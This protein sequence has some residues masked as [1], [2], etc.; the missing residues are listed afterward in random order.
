MKTWLKFGG[1]MVALGISAGIAT[2]CVAAQRPR[3]EYAQQKPPKPA[4]A[5]KA[6]N[7]KPAARPPQ[8]PRQQG[9]RKDDRPP[10]AGNTQPQGNGFDSARG[11]GNGRLTPR[12]QLSVGSPRPWV[13]QMRSLPPRQRERVLENSR[14]FQNMPSEQQSRIRQQFNQWDKLSP[15]Q[16]VDQQAREQTWRQ[17]TQEQRQ[18]IKIDVLPQWRQMSQDRRQA[19]SRRLSTLQNMPESARNQ[20]LN[21]PEFTRGMSEEDR[22]TLKDLSHLHVG[23]PPDPPAE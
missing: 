17:L 13:D 11:P 7:Q 10:Y 16:R 18:H 2:P 9:A 8:Q 19:I 22:A 23:G 15:Q 20:R 5:P 21:D 14:A 4:N 3:V 1:W 6:Q 12:Q